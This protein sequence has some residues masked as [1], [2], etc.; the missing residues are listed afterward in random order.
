MRAFVY[1]LLGGLVAVAIVA[2]VLLAVNAARAQQRHR[3]VDRA[4]LTSELEVYRVEV[5]RRWPASKCAGCPVD[6]RPMQL[7]F[8]T[9]GERHPELRDYISWCY[10]DRMR[11]STLSSQCYVPDFAEGPIMDEYLATRAGR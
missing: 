7:A 8:D 1:G 6:Y 2:G 3:Q 9:W 10:N 5:Y 4:L 11:T